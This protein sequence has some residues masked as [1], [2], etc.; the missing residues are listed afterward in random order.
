MK[1]FR[2]LYNFEKLQALRLLVVDIDEGHDV[3]KVDPAR[4]VSG[5]WCAVPRPAC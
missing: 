5:R 4:C 3:A 2:L 1:P